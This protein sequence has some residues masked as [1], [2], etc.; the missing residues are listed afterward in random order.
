MGTTNGSFL[1]SGI[2]PALSTGNAFPIVPVYTV[3]TQTSCAIFSGISVSEIVANMGGYAAV[4]D[5]ILY[6]GKN[7]ICL[8]IASGGARLIVPKG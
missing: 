7:R 1:T 6:E 3:G 4:L 2:G 8:P 5:E